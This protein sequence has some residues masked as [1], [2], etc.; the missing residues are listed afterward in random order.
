MMCALK[1]LRDKGTKGNW[2]FLK[3]AQSEQVEE[4]SE[5]SVS[6]VSGYWAEGKIDPELQH[7]RT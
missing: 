6:Y 1:E 4:P 5:C 3:Y 7:Y 2:K